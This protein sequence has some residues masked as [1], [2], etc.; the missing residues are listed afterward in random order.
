MDR[1][2]HWEKIYRE[3]QATQV[4]WYRAHL[5]ASLDLI[6]RFAASKHAAILDIGGG[7]STLADDL[8]AAGYND[9]SV[10]DIAG[11]ALAVSRLRLGDAAQKVKWIA[12][13]FLDAALEENRYGLCHDRAVFHFLTGAGEQAAY[14]RQVARILRPDGVLVLATFAP[15][16]PLRCSGLEVVR[17]DEAALKKATGARLELVESHRVSHHTPAGAVQEMMYFVLRKI[18]SPALR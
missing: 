10:L 17:Y 1:H 8:L 16:G 7:A 9:V 15:D 14:F 4:S 11:D 18:S 13:D 2:A 6:A 12:A 3:K 5:E